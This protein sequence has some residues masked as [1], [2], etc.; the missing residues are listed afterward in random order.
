LFWPVTDNRYD[1]RG[2]LVDDTVKYDRRARWTEMAVRCALILACDQSN[3]VLY[4]LPYWQSVQRSSESSSH[5]RLNID[6]IS[7]FF[8]FFKTYGFL[9]SQL[10]FHVVYFFNMRVFLL[11]QLYLDISHFTLY[12]D[13]SRSPVVTI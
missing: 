2:D 3:V 5:S 9:D 1:E 7:K 11:V 6:S 13:L 10:C 8:H 12:V 4:A